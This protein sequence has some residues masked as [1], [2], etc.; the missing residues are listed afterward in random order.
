MTYFAN[1]L[2]KTVQEIFYPA[3]SLAKV[4]TLT[5]AISKPFK[6]PT[7]SNKHVPWNLL[8]NTASPKGWMHCADVDLKD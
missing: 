5:V 2:I 3:K 6:L 7:Q 8:E 4:K 1:S